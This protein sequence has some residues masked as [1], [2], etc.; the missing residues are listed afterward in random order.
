MRG[1]ELKGGATRLLGTSL[2]AWLLRAGVVE[3]GVNLGV[4]GGRDTWRWR[5]GLLR[6]GGPDRRGEGEGERRQSDG[7][8]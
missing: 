6:A 1:S 7:D 5:R 4:E 8:G 2:G 3:S